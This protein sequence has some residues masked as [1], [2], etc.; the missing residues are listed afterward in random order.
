MPNPGAIQISRITTRAIVHLKSWM[1]ARASSQRLV[2]TIPTDCRLLTLAPG[3]WLL[4]SDALPASALRE[5]VH[6]VREQG[7]AAVGPSPGLAALELKG[8]AA[9]DV[10][11]ASCGLDLHP[12][13]FPIGS[14]TRTRLAQLPVIIDYCDA[15]PR[16]DLYVGRSYQSCLESWLNDAAAGFEGSPTSPSPPRSATPASP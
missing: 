16:F 4:I 7:F 6:H 8:P 5:H 1:P 3:E 10:L 12:A 2:P 9:W 15:K 14:C 13:N 11:A